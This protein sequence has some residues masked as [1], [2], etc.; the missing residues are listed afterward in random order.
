MDLI[1][2][3]ETD[4]WIVDYD[5][6]SNR[7]RISYFQDYHFDDECWFDA[8]EEKELDKSFPQTNNKRYEDWDI[9]LGGFKDM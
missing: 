7:Y 3:L 6:D 1:R 8:Y 4:D 5:K 9:C 2:I